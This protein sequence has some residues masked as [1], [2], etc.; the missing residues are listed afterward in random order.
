MLLFVHGWPPSN[1]NGKHNDIIKIDD[2]Y[3]DERKQG[4][5]SRRRYT[6]SIYKKIEDKWYMRREYWREAAGV[7][8][9]LEHN[10]PWFHRVQH[11]STAPYYRPSIFF[12][13]SSSLFPP[14]KKIPVA[15]KKKLIARLV[16]FGP[17]ARPLHTDGLRCGLEDL[18]NNDGQTLF[19]DDE[20]WG[21]SLNPVCTCLQLRMTFISNGLYCPGIN[22][23]GK[24]K[25]MAISV[26]RIIKDSF[27]SYAVC[28]TQQ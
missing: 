15:R 1:R 2:F 23:T 13:S 11:S 27:T 14:K 5:S 21:H 8:S 4:P 19:P 26:G 24:K 28:V 9:A 18:C 10:A 16:N 6:I 17:R 25:I 12:T 20:T 3:N 22:F 7:T